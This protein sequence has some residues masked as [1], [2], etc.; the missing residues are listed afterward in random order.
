[1]SLYSI[2]TE[3]QRLIT[4]IEDGEIPEEAIHD[5]IEGLQ[6]EW[7]ERAE[8]VTSAI[9]NLM[10]EAEMIKAE[11]DALKARRNAKENTAQRL[12]EYLSASMQAVGCANYESPRHS[13]SF[14]KSNA[15]VITDENAFIEYAFVEC[16]KALRRKESIEPDK[17]VIK[18]ML[19]TAE[20][21]YVRLEERLNIQIK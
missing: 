4:A 17:T 12:S 20:I 5:T 2:T 16:P 10:S 11:E 15:V 9:K 18:K 3:W 1:M 21:P 13:V 6:G 7:E 8:A 14:K 19:E